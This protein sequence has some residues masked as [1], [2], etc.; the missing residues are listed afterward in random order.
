M[1]LSFII[2]GLF[3]LGMGAFFKYIGLPEDAM[4][5]YWGALGLGILL[6]II[7]LFMRKY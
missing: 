6:I 7:G 1:R 4:L 5:I 3:A 2:G